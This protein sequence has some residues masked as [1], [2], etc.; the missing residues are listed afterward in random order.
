MNNERNQPKLKPN[1]RPEINQEM[2]ISYIPKNNNDKYV[3]TR[4]RKCMRHGQ[5]YSKFHNNPNLNH[6]PDPNNVK[7]KI[8]YNFSALSTKLSQKKKNQNEQ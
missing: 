8:L 2:P 1:T 4:K 6:M 7:L 3:K 5:D